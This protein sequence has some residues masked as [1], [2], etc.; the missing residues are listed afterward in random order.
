MP[1]FSDAKT[2][3]LP[4]ALALALAACGSSSPSVAQLK[5]SANSRKPS[6]TSSSG[7]PSFNAP[8]GGGSGGGAATAVLGGGGGA[9]LLK[10]SECM[11]AHG[12]PNFP[13]PSANGSIS[14]SSSTGVNPQSAQVQKAQDICGKL[15]SLGNVAPSPAEQAQALAN[16]LKFSQCMRSHGVTNFPD[17]QSSG[18]GAHIGIRIS[19]NSGL[20]PSSPIFQAAQKAC[21]GNLPLLSAGG[22]TKA[23]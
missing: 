10:F 23:P 15:L 1:T 14:I 5:S 6:S 7:G 16:A 9:K 20:D 21:Q 17:P 22:P 2:L 8:S 3:T 18:G 19:A 12:V 4:L 13:D 11:R